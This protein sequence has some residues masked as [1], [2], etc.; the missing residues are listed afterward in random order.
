M[1][2][3]QAIT[4]VS[5]IVAASLLSGLSLAQSTTDW[6]M[7]PENKVSQSKLYLSPQQALDMKRADPKA[8]AFFD[9]RTRAEATYVGMASDIDALIPFVEHQELWSDW[10]E[11]RSM[12]KVEPNQNFLSEVD[13]RMAALGLDKSAPV[14]LI[15]RSGDRSAKG[16][17]RLL[18]AGYQRVY[19]VP[20][21]FEGDLAKA[22]PQ[23]GQRVVNGWKN[24]GLP[25]TY[26]LEKAK[27]YFEK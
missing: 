17:N 18:A 4:A 19:S 23:A 3:L 26:K 8:T 22:G 10:D 1:K 5:V 2:P 15:C 13:R 24:A 16:A 21:G 14:I 12:Y 25:W 20:E 11:K 9:V 6:H 27:M 7:L